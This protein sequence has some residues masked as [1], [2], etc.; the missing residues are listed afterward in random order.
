M[1]QDIIMD[2]STGEDIPLEVAPNEEDLALDSVEVVRSGGGGETSNYNDLDN[3]PQINGVTLSGNKSLS[4]LGIDAP[5][6]EIF[7]AEYGTTTNAEIETAIDAGKAVFCEM[8]VTGYTGIKLLLVER[9]SSTCHVF[10]AGT[11]TGSIFA[12]N[13]GGTWR[14]GA[15]NIPVAQVIAYP[16]MD[17]TAT[18]GTATMYARSDH[19]HPSDTSRL[20]VNQGVA[21]A[22]KFLV[23]GSD[24]NITAV[25]MTAWA[26]GSY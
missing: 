21:N 2:V 19:V 6:P 15:N 5:E 3:K 7:W 17:D 22:G 10:A 26:G 24:G 20:A 23:V 16:L 11:E 18:I 9:T 12:E 4:D 8:T 13:N 1:T 25:T 14:Y